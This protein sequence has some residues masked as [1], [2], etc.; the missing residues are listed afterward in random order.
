MSDTEVAMQ[1]AWYSVWAA[2]YCEATGS[3]GV[4]NA[5]LKA[6]RHTLAVEWSASSDELYDVI[7]RLVAGGRVPGFPT[8]VTNG[9]VRE[10]REMRAE[11]A[12]VRST[13]HAVTSAA[14]PA[15]AFCGDTGFVT[16]PMP[17]C[18]ECPRDAPP[19]LVN[20]PGYS[21]VL[22][23]AVMC[24]QP[25]CP[26]GRGVRDRETVVRRPRPTLSAYLRPFGTTDVLGLLAEYERAHRERMR[27]LPDGPGKWIVNELENLKKLATEG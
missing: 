23:C 20:Y 16:V 22:T 9:I 26:R 10:L 14:P 19:R 25:E 12:A 21:S 6:C 1:G 17:L 4:I 5:V 7:A 24:D 15:C 11:R 13:S 18:V 2:K 27:R 3:S 8:E